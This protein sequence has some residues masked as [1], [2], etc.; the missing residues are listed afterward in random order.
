MVRS[1]SSV[2]GQDFTSTA[3]FV[4]CPLLGEQCSIGVPISIG[5]FSL[6]MDGQSAPSGDHS[7]SLIFGISVIHLFLWCLCR[8]SLRWRSSR[9]GHLQDL[10]LDCRILRYCFLF[11]SSLCGH[12]VDLWFRFKIKIFLDTDFVPFWSAW[13]LCI[14]RIFLVAGVLLLIILTSIPFSIRICPAP[15]IVIEN[16]RAILGMHWRRLLALW[17]IARVLEGGAPMSAG[18]PMT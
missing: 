3:E 10:S 11:V 18:A 2:H 8:R 1:R 16:S 6:S 15:I 12:D 5:C 14:G 13:Y 17:H 4:V 7:S 9:L